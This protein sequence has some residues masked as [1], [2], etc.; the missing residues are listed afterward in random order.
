MTIFISIASYC[1]PLLAFT[2][3]RAWRQAR[4]PEQL[5]FGIVEQDVPEARP[6]DFGAIPR[7]QI[8]HVRLDARD[9]RG[10]CWARAIGMTLHRGES[11]FLQLDSHM[12]F[13]PEWDAMLLE[14]A[15]A[16][17]QHQ[18]RF[19]ISCYPPPFVFID[20]Q[21]LRQETTRNVL[22][23]VVKP[24]LVFD[25]GHPV[26][27]FEA[28]P[29]EQAGPVRGFHL[30]AGCLFGP[31]ELVQQFPYD[32]FLY[33]HGEEQA[34]A[35]RLYTH[36]W[37]I[38]HI[39]GMPISHLYYDSAASNR[40]LH[41][42]QGHDAQRAQKWW[43]LEKRA[44]DRLTQ[45]LVDGVDLG[46]Y[47][48]GRERSLADYARFCGIDYAARQIAPVAYLGPWTVADPPAPPAE[49]QLLQPVVP[50]LVMDGQALLQEG[51][52]PAESRA[53]DASWTQWLRSNLDRGCDPDELLGILLKE[54]FA[55]APIRA[56]MGPKFPADSPLLAASVRVAAPAP[57]YA[58]IASPPMLRRAGHRAVRRVETDL[59]QIYT[60]DHFLDAAECEALCA[61]IGEHLR[62]STV[63]IEGTDRAFR[64]SRTSDLSQLHSPVVAAID[65]KISRMLGI[66][67]AY[68]EG[69]QAQRYDV[70]QQFKAHTDYFE[71]GTDEFA[72]YGGRLGNRTWTFMVYLNEGMEGGGTHFLAIDQVFQPRRG[73]AVVWNNLHADG[74]P[75]AQTLHAGLPVTQGHKVIITKWFR[76]RGIG[77]MFRED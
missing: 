22:A 76:A 12:N 67:Q 10:P 49:P 42:D 39:A 68:A 13:E 32:P 21:P 54:K 9:A 50:P 3:E 40:K 58:A 34:M 70:G 51:F 25:P 48:L 63:T 77:P 19:V 5:R 20:G 47:G 6:V 28:H 55:L 18:P 43:E 24:G 7:E 4:W 61:I 52:D 11:W 8:N 62:P 30:G 41:W 33:F 2:M 64:T 69:N 36:G 57:D 59:L 45:L 16:I 74:R 66:H 60:I 56:V 23:H 35:A 14:Q 65:E 38:F 72:T 26:L 46:V 71:P 15:Q 73:Q 27:M 1:D 17:A 75:N 29:V 53:L 44:R 31:G 37:D